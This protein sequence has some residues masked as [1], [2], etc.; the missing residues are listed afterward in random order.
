M[1]INI[2]PGEILLHD[3]I[4]PLGISQRRLAAAMAVPVSRINAIIKGKRSIEPDTAMRLARV[5]NTSPAFWLN[6]QARYDVVALEAKAEYD[7][8]EML[9]A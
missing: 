7:A 1:K 2:H 9:T 5:L 4:E 3:V 8:L 6:L